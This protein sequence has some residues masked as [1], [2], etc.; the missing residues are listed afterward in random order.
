VNA[1]KVGGEREGRGRGR[2]GERA[3]A[4]LSKESAR[5]LDRVAYFFSPVAR[6]ARKRERRKR[7]KE[8]EGGTNDLFRTLNVRGL[9]R[10]IP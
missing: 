2:G 3:S 8:G 7:G 10:P 6:S 5:V 9:G 1:T 4:S